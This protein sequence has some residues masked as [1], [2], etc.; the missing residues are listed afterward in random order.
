MNQPLLSCSFLSVIFAALPL[1]CSDDAGVCGDGVVDPGEACDGSG[2]GC[3]AECHLT[4]AAAWTVQ[5]GDPGLQPRL[6]DV[7]ID[8]AGRIV[9]LGEMNGGPPT[10]EHPGGTDRLF[11]LGLEPSGAQRWE[12]EGPDA[13]VHPWL[14]PHL[15]VAADGAF[16]VQ[17]AG[18]HAYTADG[19]TTWHMAPTDVGYAAITAADGALYT[20]GMGIPAPLARVDR[21]D[22]NTGGSVW[23][24]SFGGA[25]VNLP[26]S[27]VIAGE[28]VVTVG[29][30]MT[31]ED[32]MGTLRVVASAATGE[33]EAQA[34]EPTSTEPEYAI[35]ALAAGDLALAHYTR[36]DRWSAQR[37]SPGGEVR[38]TIPIAFGE[39]DFVTDLLTTDDDQILVIGNHEVESVPRG[40]LRAL[41]GD[42][43]QVW[44]K[45]YATGEGF[46]LRAAAGPGGVVVVGVTRD[47]AGSRGWIE[48]L[49][50]G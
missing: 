11:L 42:G 12:R 22:P 10:D 36:E 32:E 3:D 19:D 6:L 43:E 2:P 24:R 46:P 14:L 31:A 4:G 28:H 40:V 16:Y 35:D 29:F 1:A 21:L 44:E 7:G 34:F 33:P 45:Q 50:P 23:Q 17:G 25:G 15:A 13:D 18:I 27:V 41:D 48:K 38:W 8:A 37:M 30:W 5:Y 47:Q 9:V 20:A 49:G 26:T 39:Q